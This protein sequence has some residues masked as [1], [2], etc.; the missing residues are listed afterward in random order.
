MNL[1]LISQSDNRGYDTHDSAVVAAEDAE[2]A[3][4]ISPSPFYKWD[5]Y[6]DRWMFHYI[7]GSSTAESNTTWVDDVNLVKVQ[8]IG[9]AT[10]GTPEGVILSSF[11]AG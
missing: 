4:R 9:V 1:Y 10:H 3:K 8:F 5:K 2:D 7:D 11:N 6:T